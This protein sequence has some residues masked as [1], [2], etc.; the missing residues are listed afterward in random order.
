MKLRLS[1]DLTVSEN[2]N[3]DEERQEIED[4]LAELVLSRTRMTV[5][6]FLEVGEMRTALMQFVQKTQWPP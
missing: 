3:V 1:I 2:I 5:G 4:A 6:D